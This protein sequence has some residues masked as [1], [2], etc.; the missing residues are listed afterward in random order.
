[1]VVGKP[2]QFDVVIDGTLIFS[3]HAQGRFPEEE[4]ILRA[5]PE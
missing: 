5:L 4:E 2:G 3:K 1:L